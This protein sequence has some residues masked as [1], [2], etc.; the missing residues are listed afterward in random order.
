MSA[1]SE[2]ARWLIFF[3]Q[4]CW[5]GDLVFPSSARDV[6]IQIPDIPFL[7]VVS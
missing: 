2:W 5:T 3:G 7:L 4:P 6:L 1:H